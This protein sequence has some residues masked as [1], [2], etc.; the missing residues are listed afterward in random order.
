MSSTRLAGE[1][2]KWGLIPGEARFLAGLDFGEQV[3][4]AHPRV[5]YMLRRYT[6]V[7]L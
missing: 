1:F 2:D 6:T 3:T 4:A 5:S 7:M